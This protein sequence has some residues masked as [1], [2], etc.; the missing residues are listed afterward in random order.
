MKKTIFAALML[1]M[2]LA[3]ADTAS[4]QTTRF[5]GHG[6][7]VDAHTRGLVELDI[8]VHGVDVDLKAW[9][10]CDPHPCDVGNTDA[11][12]YAPNI[13]DNL[14][15]TARVL[16]VRCKESFAERLLVTEPRGSEELAAR[17]YTH[18]TDGIHRTNYIDTGVLKK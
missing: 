7:N 5:E 11:H 13:S 18:F 1:C 12:L 10:A 3:A 8:R 15:A 4:A 9:G 17:L 6:K 16:I 2:T 14:E